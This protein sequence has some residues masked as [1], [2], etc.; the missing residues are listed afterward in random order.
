M[1]SGISLRRGW[2]EALDPERIALERA[3]RRVDVMI[4]HNTKNSWL[5]SQGFCRGESG[6]K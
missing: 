5:R 6:M 1:M 4:I 2:T 3:A